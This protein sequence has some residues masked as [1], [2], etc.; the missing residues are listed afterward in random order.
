VTKVASEILSEELPVASPLP[1]SDSFTQKQL[2]DLTSEI[3][4]INGIST[5]TE[6]TKFQPKTEC[7]DD[8]MTENTMNKLIN[9]ISRF[10]NIAIQPKPSSVLKY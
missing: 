1:V 9:G 5:E 3:C 8:F 7:P 4:K 2:S 6:V 10:N